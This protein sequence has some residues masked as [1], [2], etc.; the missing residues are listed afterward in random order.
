LPAAK[1][2]DGRPGEMKYNE[3][4]DFEDSLRKGEVWERILK[5]T[6]GYLPFIKFADYNDPHGR[7]L[8]LSGIDLILSGI[9]INIEVK[10]RN[11]RYYNPKDPDIWLET[12]SV[13]GK[14]RG[15]Y[16][17]STADAIFYH[18][19]G[20]DSLKSIDAFIFNL[21]KL[22]EKK[23]LENCIEKLQLNEKVARP[24]NYNGFI[25]RSTGYLIPVSQ[26]PE[27]TI[28]NVMP[29][30]RQHTLDEPDLMETKRRFQSIFDD[31]KKGEQPPS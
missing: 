15:W 1:E 17:T 10:T 13:P 3:P 21:K 26:F 31:I 20:E 25:Y 2:K 7:R 30:V 29:L 5:E 16:Y 22:R 6:I 14:K 19:A 18:W 24:T 11:P 9:P 27:D 8:Q 4:I 28:I 12:W 23:F